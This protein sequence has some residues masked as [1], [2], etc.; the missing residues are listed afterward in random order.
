MSNGLKASVVAFL[1]HM[2]PGAVALG[3]GAPQTRKST[4]FQ[5]AARQGAFGTRLVVFDPYARRDRLRAM[6]GERVSPWPGRLYTPEEIIRRPSVL[7]WDPLQIVV[8][9]DDAATSEQMARDFQTAARLVWKVGGVSLGAEEMGRYGRQASETINQWASGSGHTGGCFFGIAQSLGRIQID[10]RRCVRRLVA[11]PLGE[12]RDM[13]AIRERCGAKF[14][15]AVSRLRPPSEDG[16]FP[17]D[18]PLTWALG[19]ERV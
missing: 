8:A 17:G 15:E 11:F 14:A 3:V 6:A 2:P 5:E 12:E 18:P 16:T 13:Y 9:G 10:A 1:M 7:C 4:Y 19:Q